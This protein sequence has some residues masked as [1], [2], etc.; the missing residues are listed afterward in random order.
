M[1]ALPFLTLCFVTI[2]A[3]QPQ[4]LTGLKICIDPGHGGNNSA[5]DRRIEPDPGN[6]FWESEG[7]FRKALWLRPMLQG[8]GATVFVTRETNTY[9]DDNLEP[10][11][12]TRVAYANSNNV[13]YFHSI[14]SNATGGVNTGTN[15]T[16]VLIREKRSLTNPAASTG[17]GM[18]IPE[19]ADSKTMADLIGPNIAA[20]NR[21]IG[22][23]TTYLDWTFYGGVSTGF[24]LGVLR[25][26]LMP[27]DLSEGS[28]HDYS[29]ETRRLLNNDYRKGEAYGI[30]NGFVEFLKIPYDT[31][32]IICG[33]QKN[34]TVPINNIVVR[35][36]PL[37]KVYNG[38]AYNNGYFMF[39]SLAPGNYS[40]VFETP[41]YAQDTVAVTLT[42][43]GRLATTTP[44]HSATAVKRNS[45]IVFN[46]IKSMDTAFVRSVFSVTPSVEGSLMWNPAL[47]VLTFTPKNLLAYK[48]AYTF[49]LAGLGNTLQPTVFVDNK[50]VTSNVGAKP[51][52]VSFTTESLP[53]SVQLTQPVHGDTNFTITQTVGIRFSQ[54]MDTASVRNAF[55]ITPPTI[56]TFTWSS[57][58]L[59][60]NTLLWKS[61]TGSLAYQTF[62]TVTI[63]SGAKSTD[64]LFIDGN[65]DSIGGDHYSFQFRTQRQPTNVELT[66][67]QPVQFALQQNFPNPF[68]PETDIQ[69]SI[70]EYGLAELI[71]YDLLGRKVET[72][73]QSA[74]APG[75]Y[76][77][78]WDA[79]RAASGLYFYT[80]R[81][82]DHRSMK[83]MMLVK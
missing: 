50:T 35:L 21:T 48:T 70:A 51:F 41:G 59:P 24:S 76:T 8:R 64:N 10:S 58:S 3:S 55:Q 79:S 82:G 54:T 33:T 72:L 66:G 29:P 38:D 9:P 73:L 81:S 19:Y 49:S 69:F 46:F 26:L 25:G 37:N 45:A 60:N 63:G 6:V 44:L 77:V 53:P 74:L 2:L 78:R 11:L 36:L 30:Y 14:H 31:L 23:P 62:Y 61:V 12:T 56:G 57:S 43:T 18:G 32:G 52:I 28:F 7:N 68:N 75:V 4:D 40:V 27:G 17:N 13:H 5:N 67:G 47:T 39:D 22:T 83:R 15:R 42:A 71:I 65:N 80:L 16:I 1:R 20:K 34:G